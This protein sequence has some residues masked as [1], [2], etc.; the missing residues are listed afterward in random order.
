MNLSFKRIPSLKRDLFDENHILVRILELRSLGNNTTEPNTNTN[1]IY[2]F[3]FQAL[4]D[5]IKHVKGW[6]EYYEVFFI[7]TF[8]QI[9]VLNKYCI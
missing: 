8:E 3:H 9:I 6:K 1:V 4:I 5:L 7:F 2:L